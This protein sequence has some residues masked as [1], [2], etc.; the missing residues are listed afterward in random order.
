MRTTKL[1]LAISCLLSPSWQAHSYIGCF[2]DSL[3]LVDI[4]RYIY[5]S[6]G[7]C[8]NRCDGYHNWVI[9]LTNGSHCLCGNTI[10]H[11]ESKVDDT[12]C[13]RPCAGYPMD[14]CKSE[15]I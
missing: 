11:M 5:Q 4:G 2:E 15:I 6:R 13:N 14:T 8:I 10:P 12:R 7:F 3:G 1:L 9:G